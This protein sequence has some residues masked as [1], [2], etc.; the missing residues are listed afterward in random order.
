[1]RIHN[2]GIYDALIKKDYIDNNLK[3]NDI[4]RI[5]SDLLKKFQKKFGKIFYK[6]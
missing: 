2:A 5:S 3:F 6:S 1:M 4:C